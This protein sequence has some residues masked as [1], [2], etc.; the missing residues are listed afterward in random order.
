MTGHCKSE[1]HPC[2]Q[3]DGK[4]AAC[5]YRRSEPCTWLSADPDCR[6]HRRDYSK[7]ECR[8]GNHKKGGNGACSSVQ[9]ELESRWHGLR[10]TCAQGI[11]KK[12]SSSGHRQLAK[13]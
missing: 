6:H 11:D 1:Q 5:T 8:P 12:Q 2:H 10:Y 9:N 7:G 13:V 4:S 3:H